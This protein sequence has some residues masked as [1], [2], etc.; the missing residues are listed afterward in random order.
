MTFR[1][2]PTLSGK[3]LLSSRS[4]VQLY[5]METILSLHPQLKLMARMKKKARD[6]G[7][8]LMTEATMAV[9]TKAG[10]DHPFTHATRS[11][12]VRDICL[13]ML[14][15][16]LQDIMVT[17]ILEQGAGAFQATNMILTIS[18][19]SHRGPSRSQIP[20]RQTI[21]MPNLLSLKRQT[22]LWGLPASE[23]RVS[24]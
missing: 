8:S 6:R 24:I 9:A 12:D 7:N 22:L 20:R 21:L 2:R 11:R 4:R 13:V 19:L 14:S 18:L 17:G 5:L 10:Q 15:R 3:P 23:G 1:Y 16:A